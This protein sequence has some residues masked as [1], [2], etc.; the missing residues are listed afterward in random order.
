MERF[1]AAQVH[2]GSHPNSL[3]A[4]LDKR[5]DAAFVVSESAGDYLARDLIDQSTLRVLWRSAPI[6]YDPYVFRGGL[7][8]G[9]TSRGFFCIPVR[10]GVCARR[11]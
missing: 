6:H 5:V 8:A 10:D 1:F 4:M 3:D 11:S 9:L 7:C 2:T